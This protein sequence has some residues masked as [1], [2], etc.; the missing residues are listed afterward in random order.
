MS[1]SREVMH[2]MLTV[3]RLELDVDLACYRRLEAMRDR[4]ILEDPTLADEPDALDHVVYAAI[5][6][7]LRASEQEA[8]VSFN[9]NTG[10][11]VSS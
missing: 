9:G 3:R 10:R 2:A 4:L 5:M 7:G 11:K 6:G 8:G 1:L